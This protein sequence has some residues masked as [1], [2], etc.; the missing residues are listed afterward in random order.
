ML[1]TEHINKHDFDGALEVTN[2]AL[3]IRLKH[4]G[5]THPRVADLYF[6]LGSTYLAL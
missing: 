6:N 3:Q 1:A 4:Y 5:E 2:K